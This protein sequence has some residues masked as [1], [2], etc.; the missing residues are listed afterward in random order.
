MSP[1]SVATMAKAQLLYLSPE[2]EGAGAAAAVGLVE[3]VNV[4]DGAGYFADEVG[5]EDHALVVVYSLAGGA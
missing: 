5:D 2:L 1:K 4:E 3:T